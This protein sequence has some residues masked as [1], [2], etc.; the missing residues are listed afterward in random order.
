L[1]FWRHFGFEFALLLILCTAALLFFPVAHGSYSTVHGPVTAL[2]SV[3]DKLR[4]WSIVAMAACSLLSKRPFMTGL[5]LLCRACMDSGLF[6]SG[7]E[8][9]SVLR[10]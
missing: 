8:Q 6:F 4:I 3:R 7:P 5:R 10:C 2:R 1:A 9:P